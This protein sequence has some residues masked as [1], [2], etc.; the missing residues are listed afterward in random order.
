MDPSAT[1]LITTNPHSEARAGLQG[2]GRAMKRAVSAAKRPPA[3]AKGGKWA[4]VRVMG[5]EHLI[6][7]LSCSQI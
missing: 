7:G 4:V 3:G 1:Q 6:S 5:L 2:N